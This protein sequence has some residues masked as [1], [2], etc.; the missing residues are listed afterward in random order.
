[1]AFWV[2]DRGLKRPK[3]GALPTGSAVTLAAWQH[4]G[5]LLSVCYWKDRVEKQAIVCAL[6]LPPA[7]MC[8]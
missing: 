2:G 7:N 1:M 5:R 8:W 6:T 3:R 4:W